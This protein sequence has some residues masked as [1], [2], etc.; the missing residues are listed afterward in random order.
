MKSIIYNLL[1]ALLVPAM[2][3][4]ILFRSFSDK[5]YRT[6]FIHRL[7]FGYPHLKSNGHKELIWFHAV[8]LGEVIGSQQIVQSLL[9]R[10]D[11]VLTV[12]TPTGLRKAQE[13]F[14]DDV[15]IV[16]A[17]WDFIFFVKRF[18]NF[19]SPTAVAIFETEIWPSMI[20]V[21]CSQRIPV[22]LL[23]GRLSARSYKTYKSGQW[24]FG[25]AFQQ[26]SYVFVQSQKHCDRFVDL[27]VPRSRL[28]IAGSSKFD[29]PALN[30][31]P[32]SLPPYVLAASTHAGEDEMILRSFKV[33][34][35]IS[36]LKLC[37]CP[38]HPDR[39]LSILALALKMGFKVSLYSNLA[40]DSFDVCIV[41]S[42]GRLSDFYTNAEVAFVGGSLIPH[43]GHNLI[44]PAAAGTPI[45]VGPHTFNFEDIVEEF[46]AAEACIQVAT[47]E[48]FCV[49]LQKLTIDNALAQTLASNATQLINGKKGSTKVQVSYIIKAIGALN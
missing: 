34:Q 49:N 5:D 3:V 11:L 7:G 31:K 17:P 22:Y 27:G 18:F 38:R 40:E 46:V 9:G 15:T 24:L 1:T 44:E 47:E 13:I 28:Q 20:S 36:S 33:L 16:Y 32:V 2:A 30:T 48:E 43:G 12:S 25:E 42:I 26:L 35:S 10:F 21:A 37:I 8:S 29:L 19:Y 14:G 41:D 6:D 23:N 39:S 45:L 4:R